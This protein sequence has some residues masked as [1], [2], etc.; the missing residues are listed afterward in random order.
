MPLF[1]ASQLSKRW[2]G[3]LLGGGH[4]QQRNDIDGDGWADLA[5]YSRGVARPR[6]FWNGGEGRSGIPHRRSHVRES[7]R[8]LRRCHTYGGAR[9]APLRCRRQPA[10]P[11][12]A[13]VML[14][15]S[16][17]RR[18]RSITITVSAKS[19]SATATRCCSAKGPSAAPTDRHTWVAGVAADREAYRPLDVTRFAYRYLTPGVFAQDDVTVA[20]WL[21]VS[22]SARVDHH[23]RY[24]TFFSPRL[25]A[26]VRW[27]GWTSRLSAGQGFFAPTPLTEETEA[28]GL[29][30]LA[31][32]A[33][34]GCRARRAA[35]PSTSLARS[36]QS[37][38]PPLSSR[39]AC[40]TLSTSIGAMSTA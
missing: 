32:P 24:G 10:N 6:F 15:Q 20:K 21:S 13:T 8:R 2:S 19:A 7:R 33:A 31:I 22:A 9:Y 1:L 29:S 11:G 16:V 4:F 5:G 40:A 38:L 27:S 36:A 26:L 30:R 34:A 37:L 18:R 39:R 17:S 23:N 28:A 35:R 14:R 25:S 3:S 12:R